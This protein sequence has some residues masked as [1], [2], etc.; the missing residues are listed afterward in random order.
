MKAKSTIAGLTGEPHF[1]ARTDRVRRRRGPRRGRPP[2]RR[3]CRGAGCD[4]QGRLHQPAHR[5]ARRIRRDRRLYSRT[6]PEGA[7]FRAQGRRQ[8]LW[9][10]NPR[11]RHPVR[12]L[13]RRSTRED[14]DQFRQDRHD[15][16][17]LDPR[18][19][20][21]GRRRMRGGGGALHVDGH[22]VGGLVFRARR[23][24]RPALAVQVDF[25][26]RLRRRRVLQDLCLAMELARDQ[27][28]SRRA[29]SQR[30]RRQRDP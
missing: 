3:L 24:A 7:R 13:A 27:Q 5:Q 20:Q 8:D 29:L 16:G 9:R 10:R 26:F 19:D 2:L 12:S 17:R 4:P 1:A 30:R 21:S 14:A 25:S 22:A 28:E 6:R 15:A 11:S 23:Q 18:D